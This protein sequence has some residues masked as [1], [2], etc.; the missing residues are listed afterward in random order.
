VSAVRSLACEAAI[1]LVL[2]G[3]SCRGSGT[4]GETVRFWALGAE[5]ES[6]E[7]LVRA[8]EGENPGVH[9]VLQRIPWSA[10]HEKLLTAFVGGSTPDV[11]QIGNTW[12]PE[13][14]SLG[15]IE[16]LDRWIAASSEIDSS[17]YFPGIWATNVLD[18][19]VYGVP[20]YVD[21]RVLFYR[22]D[23]LARAGYDVMPT[24]WKTWKEALESIQKQA[25]PGRYAI[26]L[27]VNE[28]TQP[29]IFGLQA[30][31]PLL[32]DRG[33]RGCFSEEPF[34]S[35]FRFYLDF[36]REGLTPA[37]G[38]NE[39]ANVYQEFA[40]G[41]FGMWISGPWILGELRHR[42]PP[43]LQDTWGTA[44]LPGPDGP[45]V[46]LAGGASLV[47]FRSSKHREESWRLVEFLSRPE[48]QARFYRLSGD[49]P[50]RR[51]S[52]RDSSLAADPRLRAF[53]EQLTRTV[54]TPQVPEWEQIGPGPGARRLRHPGGGLPRFRARPARPR[55]L[56]D[57]GEAPMARRAGEGVPVRGSIE[58]GQARAGRWFLVP[59][60][61][62]FGVFFVVPVVAGLLLSLTDFDL[63]AVAHPALAR[64]VGLHNYAVALRSP[65]F[66]Q[67]V[68]NTFYFVLVG[69]PLSVAVSLG[70]ALL[71]NARLVRFR[72]FFRTVYFAPVVT[73]LVAVAVV[74][75]YLYHPQYGLVNRG[76]GFLGVGPVDWL[77]DP[78]W[79]MPAIV[80]LAVWKNFGYN[81]LIFLAGLQTVPDELYEAAAIDGAGPWSRFLHVTLPGLAPTF[82]FVTVTT[83]ITQFQLFA[84]PYVMTQGGPLGSTRSVVLLMYEEGFRWWRMGQ[85]S[86][87][88]VL[89]LLMTLAGAIVQLRLA[90]RTQ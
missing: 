47:L 54:P 29:V 20:W 62:L 34:R 14:A 24:T 44:P 59:A 13:F 45:G 39:I 5:G 41:T 90:R 73:T 30:G 8:F 74:W 61:G 38:N 10:A 78:T 89:L 80:F 7:E 33:T 64:F 51:D 40:R 42:L 31:S 70:A 35:A 3:A 2:A 27:P 28:W 12:I 75:R 25:G 58:R 9:V 36:F 17:G 71:L 86:A 65:E 21:T 15:A 49:L 68:R 53:E 18:G 32:A 55:Y 83:M 52:W 48:I 50:A 87:V 88:A 19:A 63:Y 82:L 1:V 67:A 81:M 43:E 11:A 69:G 23:I 57:P 77:G 66:W 84:E 6:V 26:F 46:S 22:K 60:L 37:K 72:S 16:S 76:L 85:A 4:G 56:D 79:S